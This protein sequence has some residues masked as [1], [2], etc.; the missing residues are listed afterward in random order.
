MTLLHTSFKLC[1]SGTGFWQNRA[2]SL[3]SKPAVKIIF[4]G[5]NLDLLDNSPFVT[6][7]RPDRKKKDV[8]FGVAY[9]TWQDLQAL[10]EWAGRFKWSKALT[11]NGRALRSIPGSANSLLSF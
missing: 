11:Y 5:D 10:V 6:K 1:I 3:G 7:I 4:G 2:W 8:Y 9:G